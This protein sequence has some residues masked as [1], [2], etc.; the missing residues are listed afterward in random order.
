VN[1]LIEQKPLVHPLQ[2]NSNS[3]QKIQRYISHKLNFSK[4]P[5]RICKYKS[6]KLHNA[7]VNPDG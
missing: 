1:E 4:N 2:T 5:T 7:K 6:R 3:G